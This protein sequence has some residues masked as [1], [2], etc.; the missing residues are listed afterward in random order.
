MA[1]SSVGSGQEVTLGG[2]ALVG[3][4]GLIL[5]AIGF[6]LVGFAASAP[7]IKV[8][9]AKELLTAKARLT[10]YLSL[11]VI[12]VGAIMTG[13]S[14]RS[15]AR[16]SG[17]HVIGDGMN[18]WAAYM[19]LGGI[20]YTVG[21]G[22]KDIG[23]FTGMVSKSIIFYS[24]IDAI[25]A[26]VLI[27]LAGGRIYNPLFAIGRLKGGRW[28]ASVA[29]Y[30]LMAGAILL[31]AGIGGYVIGIVLIVVAFFLLTKASRLPVK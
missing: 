20:F 9:A 18:V 2:L 25:T 5:T 10:T 27:F 14:F 21:L 22:F 17:W 16:E 11:A 19:I 12:L 13:S 15:I 29:K 1:D 4:L 3:F 8:S 6:L 26:L 30:G 24:L 7:L 28:A 31:P 23:S